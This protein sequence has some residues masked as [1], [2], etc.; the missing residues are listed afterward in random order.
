MFVV[1]LGTQLWKDISKGL[2]KLP[3]EDEMADMYEAAVEQIENS[4]FHRYEVS[5]FSR[6]P[7]DESVHNW[8]YWNGGDYIGIGPG[9]HSRFWPKI[10][11]EKVL[12][13]NFREAHIQTLEPDPWMYEVDKN[14]HATRKIEILKNSEIILSEL[15]ATSLRTRNGLTET[16]WNQTWSK[17][18]R[19]NLTV[20]ENPPF[21]LSHLIDSDR[22]CRSFV[23]ENILVLGN[24][25]KLSPK[26]LNLLDFVLPYLINSLELCLKKL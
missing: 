9:A 16:I 22:K 14:G 21:L 25:L 11:E 18:F 4:N 8:N 10:S 26:G 3:Q 13:S 1:S 17:M 6:T 15:L 20:F 24:G 5:N 19:N 7:H 23:S 2:T 12:I